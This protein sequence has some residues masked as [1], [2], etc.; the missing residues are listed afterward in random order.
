[1][2]ARW[3]PAAAA[4]GSLA[5]TSRLRSTPHN[6]LSMLGLAAAMVWLRDLTGP[7]P[8]RRSGV[9]LDVSRRRFSKGRVANY[10]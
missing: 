4:P 10:S 2:P 7:R 8:P 6:F 5:T 1:M 9:L 3:R